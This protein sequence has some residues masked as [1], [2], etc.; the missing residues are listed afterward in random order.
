MSAPGRR[1]RFTWTPDM[2]GRVEGLLEP[3]E[4]VP[5][6]PHFDEYGSCPGYSGELTPEEERHVEELLEDA[7]FDVGE[8]SYGDWFSG[9]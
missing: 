4:R 6:A 7:H 5:H 1:E 2:L 9:P 3:C 8:D